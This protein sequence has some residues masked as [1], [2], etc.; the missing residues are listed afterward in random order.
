MTYRSFL[1]RFLSRKKAVRSSGQ[2]PGRQRRTLHLETLEDRLAP[3]TLQAISLASPSL[4]AVSAG[5]QAP[6]AVTP[7]EAARRPSLE[8]FERDV[9]AVRESIFELADAARDC[10]PH[11]HTQLHVSLQVIANELGQ[12]ERMLVTARDAATTARAS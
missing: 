9:H 11:E 6:D 2:K 12:L 4:H 5:S 8:E 1:F 7:I 3:A 10:V